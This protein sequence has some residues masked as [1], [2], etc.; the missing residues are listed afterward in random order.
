MLS[1]LKGGSAGSQGAVSE[2]AVEANG[3]RHRYLRA[4]AGPLV[5][6]LHGF[7]DTAD[8]WIPVMA[9]LA[10]QG[11]RA[12][13]PNLRGYPPTGRAPDGD[14][15]LVAGA[16]DVLG[17]ADALGA[18]RLAVAGVDWGSFVAYTAANVDPARVWKVAGS[19]PH[20]RMLRSWRFLQP[21][22][23]WRVRHMALHQVPGLA[24]RIARR[25][26]FAYV[27]RLHRRWSPG[28]AFEPGM[29]DE[30]K[31]SLA[32]PGG[33]S[34]ALGWYRCLAAMQVAPWKAAERRI[35]LQSTTV[36]AMTFAGTADAAVPADLHKN[37]DPAF[38]GGH[39]MVWLDGVGHVPQ[40]ERPDETAAAIL[41]FLGSNASDNG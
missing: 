39:R 6:L 10:A 20:P 14:Y 35:V 38:P 8:G 1:N 27:D 9:R 21:A 23:L 31:K 15:S 25:H 33:L 36:D 5:V 18:E 19:T 4:G 16:R 3:I 41:D 7:P 17:I 34:G 22:Q 26:D 37:Q 30:V 12:V 13:A 24:E 2:G 11:Y 28:W 40:R 29:T 32:A